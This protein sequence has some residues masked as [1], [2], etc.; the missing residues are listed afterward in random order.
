MEVEEVEEVEEG[1]APPEPLVLYE[2]AAG[3]AAADTSSVHPGRGV[4]MF[5]A[6]PWRKV[7][8]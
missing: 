5:H 8:D 2:V 3:V 4:E 7:K 6:W 1:G